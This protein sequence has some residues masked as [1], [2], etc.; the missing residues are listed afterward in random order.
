MIYAAIT[1]CVL[2]E[3]ILS[4]SQQQIKSRQPRD[5]GCKMVFCPTDFNNDG[6]LT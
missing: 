2:T 4:C 5:D 1:S 6:M 3:C